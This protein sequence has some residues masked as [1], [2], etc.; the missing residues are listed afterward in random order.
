MSI[1]TMLDHRDSRH[2]VLTELQRG[3]VW[4]RDQVR[5]LFATRGWAL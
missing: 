2:M 5:G 4:N 3:C 1:C